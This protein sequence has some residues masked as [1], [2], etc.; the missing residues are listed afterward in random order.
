MDEAQVTAMTLAQAR[1]RLGYSVERL[2]EVR[3]DLLEIVEGLPAEASCP[4]SEELSGVYELDAVI[5]CAL[6]DHLAPLLG[7][8]R[9]LLPSQEEGE[10]EA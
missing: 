4:P 10:T 7:S 3:A 9:S 8:L 2:D 6:H 1:E 5:R